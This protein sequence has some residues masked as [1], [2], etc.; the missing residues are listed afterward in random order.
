MCGLV[1]FRDATQTRALFEKVKPTHVIH[2]AAF[3]GGLFRNLKYN[4]DFLVSINL[5]SSLPKGSARAAGLEF[6]QFESKATCPLLLKIIREHRGQYAG[7]Q[8]HI[9]LKQNIKSMQ[10][11]QASTHMTMYANLY[12][13]IMYRYIR[14]IH[15]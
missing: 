5:L 3:V 1:S 11:K 15:R 8:G 2:L 14:Q 9:Y 12:N 7:H 10:C 13:F 4:L 6:G